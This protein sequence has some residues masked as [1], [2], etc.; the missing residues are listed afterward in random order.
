M[1]QNDMQC[2]AEAICLHMLP[3]MSNVWLASII[4]YPNEVRLVI[5]EAVKI[6]NSSQDPYKGRGNPEKMMDGWVNGS[7][8]LI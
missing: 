6:I 4:R 1:G 5:K 8:P 2:L 3:L 7:L